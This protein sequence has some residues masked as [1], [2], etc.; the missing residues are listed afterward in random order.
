VSGAEESLRWTPRRVRT[1]FALLVA[2]ALVLPHLVYR[3]FAMNVLC[4]ALFA[5]ALNLLLGYGG[6]PSFC[7]AAFLGGAGYLTGYGLKTLGLTTEVAILLGTATATTL[8]ALIGGLAIRRSGIC[9]AVITLGLAQLVYFLAV[10]MPFTGGD[11]GLQGVPGG[12]LFGLVSL[13]GT[14]PPTTSST[15][16]FSPAHVLRAIRENGAR[17][18]SLG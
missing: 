1:P 12:R 14:R 8:G 11:D 9:F 16:S 2:G 17:A 4:I 6:L 10:R 7:H 13:E 18:L 15:P 3:V 5:S